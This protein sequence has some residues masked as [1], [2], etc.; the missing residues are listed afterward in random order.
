MDSPPPD[1]GLPSVTVLYAGDPAHEVAAALVEVVSGTASPLSMPGVDDTVPL[2]SGPAD[3]NRA[4]PVLVVAPADTP[5]T[6]LV[7]GLVEAADA[8]ARTRTRARIWLALL[9]PIEPAG[10][11]ELDTLLDGVGRPLLDSVVLLGPATA[12]ACA[13]SLAAW[14]HLRHDAPSAAF[15]DLRDMDGNACRFASLATVAVASPPTGTRVSSPRA[16]GDQVAGTVRTRVTAMLERVAGDSPDDAADADAC[17]ASAQQDILMATADAGAA[18]LES[19]VAALALATD[20]ADP[21]ARLHE[22]Q[23]RRVRA[24][25]MLAA[26][27]SRSGLAAKFGRKRRL[28]PLTDEL[29]AAEEDLRQAKVADAQFAAAARLR[30]ALTP[31]L[32]ARASAATVAAEQAA[33]ASEAA[34]MTAWWDRVLAEATRVQVP[35]RVRG[36]AMSRG[37]GDAAPEVRRYLLVPAHTPIDPAQVRAATG[38][39]DGLAVVAIPGLDR[40]LAA[41]ILLGLTLPAT[42]FGPPR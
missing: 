11:A 27:T 5:P 3:P 26:E 13:S 4:A 39:P 36:D 9:P 24:E 18:G 2:T 41:A 35:V 31:E 22:A 30:D 14:L 12:S 38:D 1:F 28:P 25:S 40:P 16:T 7:T 32:V 17:V 29:A 15:A 23:L 6:E 34:A 19:A 37:W 10:L 20:T 8:A 42:D 21:T 33:V